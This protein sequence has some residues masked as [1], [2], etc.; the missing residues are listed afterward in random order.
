MAM[1]HLNRAEVTDMSV[2][3]YISLYIFL[4]SKGLGSLF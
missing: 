3:V 2:F 4:E 1:V